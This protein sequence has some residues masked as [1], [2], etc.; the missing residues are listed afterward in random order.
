MFQRN[1]LGLADA[2]R[3]LAAVLEA[4][5]AQGLAPAVAIA[6]D[7]GELVC[8]ARM[9]DAPLSAQRAA[10]RKAYTAALMRAATLEFREQM[11]ERGRSLADYGDPALTRLQGGKP[12]IYQGRCVG[13][14]GVAGT[15]P[16]QDEALADLGVRAFADATG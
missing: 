16:A 15:P 2:Q 14:I 3:I 12:L 6:D 5:Q 13:A 11:R 7:H 1:C 10:R 4:A 8:Y 9:D